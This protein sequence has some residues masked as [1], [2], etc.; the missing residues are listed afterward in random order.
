MNIQKAFASGGLRHD[1][2]PKIRQPKKKSKPPSY[3]NYNWGA[4]VGP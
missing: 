3:K 1:S 4:G 2:G